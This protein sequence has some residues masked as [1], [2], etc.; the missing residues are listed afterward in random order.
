MALTYNKIECAPATSLSTPTPALRDSYFQ[1]LVVS[2]GVYIFLNN[3][4][5][6]LHQDFFFNFMYYMVTPT[7]EN[8]DFALIVILPS[9]TFWLSL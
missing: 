3:M 5:I 7:M 4:L 8:T 1:H 6:L 2:S 9:L